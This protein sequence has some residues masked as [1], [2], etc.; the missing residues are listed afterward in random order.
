MFHSHTAEPYPAGEADPAYP[1]NNIFK[2]SA[3]RTIFL[4]KKVM[5]KSMGTKSQRLPLLSPLLL[6]VS[7]KL[8]SILGDFFNEKGHFGGWR[9]G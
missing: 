4:S 8:D 7:I 1:V 9:G 3:I 6:R 2:K 5:G